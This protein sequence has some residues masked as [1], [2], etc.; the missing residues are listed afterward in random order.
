[1]SGARGP[2]A[3]KGNGRVPVGPGPGEPSGRPEPRRGGLAEAVRD[4]QRALLTG[5]GPEAVERLGLAQA[6]LAWQEVMAEAGL[7]RGGME[8]RLVRVDGGMG[9]VEASEAILA[10]E[11]RLRSDA[12]AWSTNRRM[13]GRPGAAVRLQRLTVSVRRRRS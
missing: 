1:V 9:H 13:E 5:L 7:D 11:L 10:Q 2:R 3:G 6:Q 12:L 8:S 4:V